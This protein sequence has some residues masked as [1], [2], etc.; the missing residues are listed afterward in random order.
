MSRLTT[1]YNSI[2]YRKE[3]YYMLDHFSLK[4]KNAEVK[5]ELVFYRL[6]QMEKIF[7]MLA[8]ITLLPVLFSC[9]NLFRNETGHPLMVILSMVVCLIVSF[10]KV[11]ATLKKPGYAV[12]CVYAYIY[13]M[14][15]ST[16][17][18]YMDWIPNSLRGDKLH[19]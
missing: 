19:F 14:C 18:V 7:P 13:V 8:A 4:V 16:S 9:F 11:F 3:T 2:A 1:L 6:K 5:R 15:I 12:F 10:I 17:L